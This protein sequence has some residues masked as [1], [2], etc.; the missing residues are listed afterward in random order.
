MAKFNSPR[1]T[2]KTVNHEGHAAYQMQAKEKLVTQ[3]LTSF[4]NE[5]KFYGDNSGDILETLQ[6]VI[7]VDPEFVSNLAVFARREFNMRSISHVLTAYL[8][9]APEGKPFVRSTVKGVAV[10]GDDITEIMS[11]YLNSFGKPIPNSLKKGI[12]DVLKTLDEYS[13]AKYK[14][15]SKSVK[16]RDLLCLCRPKP[17]NGEQAELWSRCLEGKLAIPETW[18]TQLSARGNT[19]EV[20]E[21]LIN[22][23]KVGYMALLRNLRN[24]IK[25]HPDNLDKVYEKLRDPAAV[26]KSKQLPFRYLSAYKTLK[27]ECLGSSKTYDVLEDALDASIANLPKLPGKTVIAIDISGS[28]SDPVSTKSNVRCYEIAMLLG[29]IANR[30]CDDAI[31]YTFNNGV[32]NITVPKRISIL[33]EVSKARCYGGTYMELPFAAVIDQKVKADRII[34]LSDNECNSSWRGTV[35]SY[36]DQYRHKTGNDIWVHAID[37]QGYGTQQFHGPKTNVIAGWSEKVFDFIL[38]AEEGVGS[39]EKKIS[40][41]TW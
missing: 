7:R 36:A 40:E 8:A 10:R 3:V 23:G 35:Q 31:V 28:M 39:L 12:G 33:N 11:C 20:W 9:H 19:K 15:E 24:I 13:L 27:D 22:G 38:L 41:Y 26:R 37:L 30:I 25:A 6:E 18:E 1:P 16:M 5:E 2:I 32:Y 14:G 17:Q 34:I 4:F 21:D 29:L